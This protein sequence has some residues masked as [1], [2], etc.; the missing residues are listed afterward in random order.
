[1]FTV[2]QKKKWE[3]SQLPNQGEFRNCIILIYM[4]DVLALNYILIDN[5]AAFGGHWLTTA[6]YWRGTQGRG[7][8]KRLTGECW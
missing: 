5:I 7:N 6:L 2:E 1:M 4:N 3:V 8:E